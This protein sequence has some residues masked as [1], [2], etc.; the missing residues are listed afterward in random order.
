MTRKTCTGMDQDRRHSDVVQKDSKLSMGT[1]MP[2]L[3]KFCC[4]PDL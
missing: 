2:L 1:G 3:E 4:D